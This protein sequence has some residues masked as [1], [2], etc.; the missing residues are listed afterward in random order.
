[1]T[2]K[3]YK[4][5]NPNFHKSL[6]CSNVTFFESVHFFSDTVVSSPSS[7]VPLPVPVADPLPVVLIPVADSP[8][9]PVTTERPPI[10]QVYTHRRVPT[11][12]I[13][14]L[15]TNLVIASSPLD[16]DLPIAL[17][18]D[19]PRSPYLPRVAASRGRGTLCSTTQS[20]VGTHCSSSW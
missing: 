3:G 9:M 7:V 10:K 11:P 16:L 4:C 12:P 8:S 20:H 2:Q 13:Q 18:K 6:V 14:P 17:R 19:C 1:M 5:Y 15:S